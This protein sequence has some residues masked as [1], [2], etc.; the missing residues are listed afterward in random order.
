MTK[1]AVGLRIYLTVALEQ[2]DCSDGPRQSA[3]PLL[4]R[5]PHPCCVCEDEGMASEWKAQ[6]SRR[7]AD[8]IRAGHLWVYKSDVERLATD[9]P[10]GALVEVQD[11]RG[12][13]LGT[14]LYSA[15]SEIVLR[16]ISSR[17]ALDRA[18]YVND[19]RERL[20]AAIRLREQL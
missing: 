8:R 4:Q 11:A 5:V 14:A 17:G 6:I 19:V 20:L 9:V 13:L 3:T 10:G 16:L 2:S 1:D 12:V 7:A 18:G 15:G